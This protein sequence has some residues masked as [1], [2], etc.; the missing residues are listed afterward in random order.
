MLLTT[1]QARDYL[2]SY[3][4]VYAQWPEHNHQRRARV[5]RIVKKHGG[6]I[7]I[8]TSTGQERTFTDAAVI[9]QLFDDGSRLQE[10]VK[11]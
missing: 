1:K 5:I 3:K 9:Q 2:N 8:H 6:A 7:L 4:P 10:G 11:A